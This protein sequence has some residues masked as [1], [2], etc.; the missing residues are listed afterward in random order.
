MDQKHTWQIAKPARSTRPDLSRKS[1]IY[2]ALS[3]VVFIG[4]I[5]AVGRDSR[6]GDPIGQSSAILGSLIL[7]MPLGFFLCKRSGY[8]ASPPLWF[9]LHAL[10]GFV[11]IVFVAIHVAS[12]S[13]LSFALV[14]L[15]SLLFLVAQGFWV[16]AFL[17]KRLS[18]LFARSAS[19]FHY[20]RPLAINRAAIADII[21]RKE[22][23][24]TKL[25]PLADEATF[26]PRLRHWVCLPHRS[27]QYECLATRE[28]KLIGARSRSGVLLSYS[29]RLHM[30]VALVFYIGLL[31]HVAVMLF[32]AGYAAKGDEIYWWHIADWGR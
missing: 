26:S 7:C 4:I 17:T 14:P 13:A 12:V 30:V 21:T 5:I 22:Q 3:A 1:L 6:P 20:G 9:V 8:S 23:L 28:A 19:S 31:A 18:Y 2:L 25:D 15:A 11:G 29:R 10:S 16:R 27:L 32:F 24:L